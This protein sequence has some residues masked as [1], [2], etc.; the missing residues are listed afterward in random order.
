MFSLSNAGR[1]QRGLMYGSRVVN[2]LKGI[3]I[4]IKIFL[5]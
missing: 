2:R 4:T 1:N 3:L 5:V